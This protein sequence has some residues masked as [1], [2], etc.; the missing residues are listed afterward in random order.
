MLIV[1]V[2]LTVAAEN[3]KTAERALAIEAP[4]ARALPG[5]LG[6][7]VWVDPDHPGKLRLMHEWT[8]A[9]QFEAYKGSSAFKA[10]GAVLFP[11]MIGAP[12]SRAFDASERA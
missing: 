2:D 7:S 5:N 10:A 1:I 9:A 4:I 12:S 6:Y 3:A 11:L 8:D